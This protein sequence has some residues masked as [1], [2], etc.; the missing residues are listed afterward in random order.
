MFYQRASNLQGYTAM[1]F[2]NVG[3]TIIELQ[4][5]LVQNDDYHSNKPPL[6]A[7]R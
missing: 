6:V 5:L 3:Y 7:E 2:A 4:N 1:A